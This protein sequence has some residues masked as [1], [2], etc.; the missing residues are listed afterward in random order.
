MFAHCLKTVHSSTLGSKQCV[1]KKRK[2]YDLLCSYVSDVSL[3]KNSPFV[4]KPLEKRSI[5]TKAV[6]HLGNKGFWNDFC[7]IYAAA[8]WHYKYI[9][10]PTSVKGISSHT[11]EGNC[12]SSKQQ[13]TAQQI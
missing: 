9:R 4:F 8:A 12:Y 5:Y 10:E 11:G 6:K 13:V 2:F 7:E 3:L 1:Q